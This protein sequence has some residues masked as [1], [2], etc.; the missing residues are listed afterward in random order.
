MTEY[1]SMLE[2]MGFACR[3]DIRSEKSIYYFLSMDNR[4]EIHLTLLECENDEKISFMITPEYSFNI[5]EDVVSDEYWY[6]TKYSIN[7]DIKEEYHVYINDNS[8]KLCF[9]STAYHERDSFSLQ[10]FLNQSYSGSYSSLYYCTFNTYDDAADGDGTFSTLEKTGYQKGSSAFFK[11]PT[12]EV[13]RKN[14]SETVL[15]FY[16]E[17]DA[18]AG[19]LYKFDGLIDECHEKPKADNS[20]HEKGNTS[21]SKIAVSAEQLMQIGNASQETDSSSHVLKNCSHCG[22]KGYDRCPKCSG[23]G[24]SRCTKCGGD[25]KSYST[26]TK[27]EKKCTR[28]FGRGKQDC[29]SCTNGKRYCGFCNGTGHE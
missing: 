4:Q 24:K 17:I 6:N 21:D 15:Y 28:C 8:F 16:A 2:Q 12:V 22:G 23:T 1:I 25:G 26:V 13:L 19:S 20:S 11:D 18:G 27:T 7:E 10:D 9:S 14:A 3:K 29:T 5:K